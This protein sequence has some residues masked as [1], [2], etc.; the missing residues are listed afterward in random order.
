MGS[1]VQYN[2]RILDEN[3]VEIS[4]AS[5]INEHGVKLSR[6]DRSTAR[7]LVPSWCKIFDEPSTKHATK[8]CLNNALDKQTTRVRNIAPQQQQRG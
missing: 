2:L 4:L 8:T 3:T 7:R 5:A 6:G 1:F